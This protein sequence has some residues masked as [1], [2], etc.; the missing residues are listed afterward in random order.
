MTQQGQ[1]DRRTD[2]DV[3]RGIAILLA[4]G[5]HINSTLSGNR[6]LDPLLYPGHSIGWAGVDIFFVLSGFLVGGMIFREL[7]QTGTFNHV[8]FYSRRIW[9]LWPTLYTFIL[10]MLLFGGMG[11]SDGWKIA[12]HVQ[13]YCSLRMAHHLWSLAVEE[14]FYLLFSLL[15][16][17]VSFLGAGGRRVR[18]ILI[19]IMVVSIPLR[20][21]AAMSGAT[22]VQVQTQTQYRLDGLACGV[23]LAQ[24]ALFKPD[25]FSAIAR[26]K[27][28]W[29]AATAVFLTCVLVFGKTSLAGQTVG[30]TASYLMGASLLLLAYQSGIEH[31]ARP[32]AQTLAFLGQNAYT[33]YLFHVPV[34]GFLVRSVTPH[35]ALSIRGAADAILSYSVSIVV[36]WVMSMTIERPF[37]RLRDRLSPRP[38]RQVPA[39]S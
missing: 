26:Q 6:V 14:H 22:A 16:P 25:L 27:A 24:I 28:L 30:L 8:R 18:S 5:W 23:L 15:L 20:L 7:H 13:N 36:A 4:M 21:L 31:W 11:W 17:L 39:I 12:A 3:V 1:H 34:H 9:R 2:L 37:M 38:V 32:V 33:L 10:V 35:V 29:L 19:A